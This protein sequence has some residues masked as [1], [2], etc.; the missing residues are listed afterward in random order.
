MKS[1]SLRVAA[2]VRRFICCRG[3]SKDRN[4]TARGNYRIRRI[5]AKGSR[6]GCL[7]LPTP[8]GFSPPPNLWRCWRVAL[9]CCWSEQNECHG[10]LK[11]ESDFKSMLKLFCIGLGE[12]RGGGRSK[13]RRAMATSPLH[14][15]LLTGFFF[16]LPMFKGTRINF[17]P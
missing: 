7:F 2:C 14:F 11:Q 5:L 8:R 16:M 10:N 12:L 9:R 4:A 13:T 6:S 15:K 1:Y 3:T 17:K